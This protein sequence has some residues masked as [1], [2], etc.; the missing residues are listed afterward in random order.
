MTKTRWAMWM[1]SGGSVFWCVIASVN[2][3]PL[4]SFIAGMWVGAAL[5]M[6]SI[7]YKVKP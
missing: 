7:E 1:T 4:T 3:L 6:I 2:G 5:V